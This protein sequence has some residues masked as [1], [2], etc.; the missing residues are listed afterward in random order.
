MTWER[1]RERIGELLARGELEV[2][3]ASQAPAGRLVTEAEKH[4]AAAG[5]I[6]T[7][8]ERAAISSRPGRSLEGEGQGND[9]KKRKSEGKVNCPCS[10][11]GGPTP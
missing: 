11:E 1:G 6:A 9:Q 8:D 7:M 3:T 4:L 10:D 5:Q 2:V